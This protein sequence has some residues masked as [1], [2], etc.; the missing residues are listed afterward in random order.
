MFKK[1]EREKLTEA[2]YVQAAVLLSEQATQYKLFIDKA[3]GHTIDTMFA[4]M[5]PF[6]SNCGLACELMLKALLCYQKCDY[7]YELKNSYE[8]HA[9]LCL[10]NLLEGKTKTQIMTHD[11]FVKCRNEDFIENLKEYSNVFVELR[12]ANEYKKICVDPFFLPNLMVIL[13]KI[14][15]EYKEFNPE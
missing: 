8:R 7:I 6:L 12:Y 5:Y 14:L 3:S 10:F 2:D 1:Q 11:F 4:T 13:F 15:Q 9:L